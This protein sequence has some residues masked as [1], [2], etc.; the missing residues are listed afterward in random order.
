MNPRVDA[1]IR[2]GLWLVGGLLSS[3]IFYYIADDTPTFR[4]F[5]VTAGPPF[6]TAVRSLMA[7]APKDMWNG[8]E[9]R[10]NTRLRNERNPPKDKW[11][12]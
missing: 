12:V 10:F 6:A 7:R 3:L 2:G 8:S 5:V 1:Y 9:R 4:E 11:A